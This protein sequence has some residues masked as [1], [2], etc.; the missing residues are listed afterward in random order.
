T[1]LVTPNGEFRPGNT[2]FSKEDSKKGYDSLVIALKE[3]MQLKGEF[4]F[5]PGEEKEYEK[6]YHEFRAS[7][8]DKS[9]KAGVTG[10]IHMS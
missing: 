4:Q 7:Y 5:D 2:L 1:F 10:R 6:W 8:K 9:D 3:I